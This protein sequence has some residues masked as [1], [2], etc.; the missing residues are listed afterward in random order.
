MLRPPAAWRSAIWPSVTVSFSIEIWLRIEG[1]GRAYR[2]VDRAVG[3]NV[4]R[5]LRPH[6][7]H[8]EDQ[9]LA[10]QEGRQFG[11]HRKGL[12]G[13][14][15]LAVGAAGDSDIREGHRGKR[16]QLRRC[17]AL[18]GDLAAQNGARLALEIGPIARPVDKI[19]HRP[20]PPTAPARKS[21]RR[22]RTGGRA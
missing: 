18:N 20:A 2:P 13:H 4:D 17:I 10:A 7:P 16:Q 1:R 12:D 8:V 22:S 19:R 21:H 14:C 3:G 9:H 5:R 11:V 15:R 6:Q